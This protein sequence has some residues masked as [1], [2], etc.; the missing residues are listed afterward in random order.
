MGSVTHNTA[1]A[2]DSAAAPS[3]AVHRPWGWYPS[4]HAGASHQVKC[5]HV[6]A[7]ASLS[8]Q[9]HAQRAEH[10]VVV[11]GIAT[12]TVG[13]QVSD[14]APNQHIYIPLGAKHRLQNH[15]ALPVQVVEVQ[16]GAYLGEDDIVRYDDVYGRAGE[17]AVSNP[18]TQQALNST[19]KTAGQ[20]HE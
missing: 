13:E 4:V 15:T 5:I 9:S 2:L 14:F 6:H 11:A 16:F 3:H 7:G 20:A 12:V 1:P 8:L 17:Q 19:F 10:W 18:A